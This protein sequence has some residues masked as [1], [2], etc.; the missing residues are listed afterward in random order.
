MTDTPSRHACPVCDFELAPGVDKCPNCTTDLRL[1]TAPSDVAL[2]FYNE[3]LDMARAGDRA[4][5]LEK[6]RGALAADP[7]LVDAYIV[8]GKLLA[9]TEKTADLEQAIAYW[10][11]ARGL[12]PTGE[13]NRKLDNC[14]ERADGTLRRL[15]R[16]TK[17]RRRNTFGGL[18]AGGVVF[19]A[20]CGV[21][22]YSLHPTRASETRIVQVPA[23]DHNTGKTQPPEN[24][25]EAVNKALNRPDIMVTQTG[26]KL[27]LAGKVASD[28]ERQI[29]IAAAALAAKMPEGRID[30]SEL[31]VKPVFRS[32]GS[33]R[34]EHMLHLFIGGLNHNR[35]DPLYGAR[36]VVTGGKDA[37]PLKVT[38]TCLSSKAGPEIISL[39]KEVYPSANPVDVTDLKVAPARLAGRQAAGTPRPAAKPKTSGP[40]TSK[41]D[42]VYINLT[43]SSYTVQPG[44]SIYRITQK[45]RHGSADWKSLYEANRKV[46]KNPNSIPTGTVLKLPPGWHNS[47]KPDKTDSG[48]P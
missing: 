20:V 48:A 41:G 26:D 44:D 15:D 28:S 10:E 32:V 39:V 31:K 13:Q 4:G 3:G 2:D 22:G 33:R 14:I 36:L 46:L 29:T 5:A 25:V 1:F 19:A 35:T 42:H 34:V 9:Q 45:Y 43:K 23:K 18:I 8:A 7:K 40:T 11:K 27:S 12:R 38:G 21:A 47:E 24:P 30:A 37:E 16:Q 17:A 6:M